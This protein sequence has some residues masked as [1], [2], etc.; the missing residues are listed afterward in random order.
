MQQHT[1][2]GILPNWR[3]TPGKLVSYLDYTAAHTGSTAKQK[4]RPIKIDLISNYAGGAT[5]EQEA[6]SNKIGLIL[7]IVQLHSGGALTYWSPPC[8]L[9][10]HRRTCTYD[11]ALTKEHIPLSA[12][13]AGEM[14]TYGRNR[15]NMY[16]GYST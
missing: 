2:G 10:Q 16:L 12:T 8:T 15:W 3:P 1:R 7:D 4:A 14:C 5:A 13:R 6:H 11:V 9:C